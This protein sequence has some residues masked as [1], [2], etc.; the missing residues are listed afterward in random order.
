MLK[1]IINNTSYYFPT[2]PKE[3][4][5][6][7]GKKIDDVLK[8]FDYKTDSIECKKWLLAEILNTSYET[9]DLINETHVNTLIDNSILLKKDLMLYF[10]PYLKLKHRL[11]KF[12][13][14]ENLN[15]ED[16]AELESFI[17]D[18][19]FDNLIKALFKPVKFKLKNIFLKL[20]IKN[21]KNFDT[22][23]YFVVKTFINNFYQYKTKL[24]NNY[25]LNAKNPNIE[26]EQQPDKIELTT[27]EKWGTYHVLMNITNNDFFKVKKWF[28][29]DIKTLFKYL[30]YIKLSNIKN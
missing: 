21:H 13:D 28:K 17:I 9:I 1:L 26:D 18:N 16:F 8:D 25:G 22:V 30:L 10:H 5:W 6:K 24:L 7:T 3:L 4:N 19:D 29:E 14:L 11:Y 12:R 20:L 27:I 23:N 15:V 2:L